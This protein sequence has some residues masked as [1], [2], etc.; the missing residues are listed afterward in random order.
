[1]N[2]ILYRLKSKFLG[3]LQMLKVIVSAIVSLGCVAAFAEGST[4]TAPTKS[5]MEA[6][7]TAAPAKTEKPA[8]QEKKAAQ[9]KDHKAK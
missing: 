2:T 9:K 4:E 6:A 3:G 5:A 8:K 1:V 7:P